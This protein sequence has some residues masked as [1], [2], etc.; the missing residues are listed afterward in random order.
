M[1]FDLRG[2]SGT[3]AYKL[4]T[5]LVVPRPIAWVTS[6]DERGTINL[7]PFSFFNLVGSEPPIVVIGVGNERDGRPKHTA[8]N[9]AATR[10]FVVNLVTEE[11]MDHMNISAADFPEGESELHAARLHD[12]ASTAVSVPRVAEAKAAL[13]CTLTRIDRIGGNNLII[14]E[15]VGVFADDTI[16]NDR[17]HVH[18]FHPVARLGGPS[19]YA[20]LTDRFELPRISYAQY[21]QET[22][23]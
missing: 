11:L 9:I 7:A 10:E 2:P 6:K 3:A 16:I 14:G 13:E 17:L 5:N 8:R 18:D 23:P 1:N 12:A 15:V 4:L 22:R 20:R 21:R 19:W